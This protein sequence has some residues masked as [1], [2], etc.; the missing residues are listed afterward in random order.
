MR[1]MAEEKKERSVISYM[2]DDYYIAISVI[3]AL[4]GISMLSIGVAMMWG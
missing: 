4:I 3:S 2:L 1:K